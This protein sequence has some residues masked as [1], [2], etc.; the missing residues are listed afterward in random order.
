MAEYTDDFGLLKLGPGDTLATDN[1]KFGT[2]DRDLI[3]RLLRIGAETH[4]HSGAPAATTGFDV[5]ARSLDLT[6]GTDSGQIPAGVRVFYRFSLVDA[7][8]F[9]SEL[10]DAVYVDTPNPV[11]SPGAP[12]AVSA[13]TGGSLLPGNYYYQLTAYTGT[14]TQETKAGAAK[15]IL[16]P[17]GTN[18]NTVT[19]TLPALPAGATG[20][21]IYR[22][23]PGGV[24]YDYLSSVVGSG[25]TY[26]DT[27]GV[28]EDCNRTV[29]TTNYTASQNHVVVDLIG[30]VLPAGM[31]WRLYRTYAETDYNDSRI[32][33][34]MTLT[35][36]DDLGTA[37][38][39]SPPSQSLEVASP[40]KIELTDMEE[41]QGILPMGAMTFPVVIP[42]EFPGPIAAMTGDIPWVCEYPAATVIGCRAFI[43]INQT[44]GAGATPTDI[45]VDVNKGTSAA[46]TP[47]TIYTTQANRPRIAAGQFIG[48]RTIPDTKTLV[49]GDFLTV[50]IDDLGGEGAGADSHITVNVYLVAHGFVADEFVPGT[51][52]GVI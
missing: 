7:D 2:E 34:G 35:T 50:D 21:N 48:T 40:S 38:T 8:G 46:P 14:N 37:G 20:F 11:A 28:E 47:T 42:F 18:T 22:K 24:R 32:A 45:I 39:G 51:S 31:T 29:P 4:H 52:T 9:E 30:D 6:H 5:G 43:G 12:T 33:T 27:G 26:I 1:Y 10:S 25:P 36:F 49:T 15:Y 3:A 23:K 44:A 17:S 19:L 41:V 13:N 16:V